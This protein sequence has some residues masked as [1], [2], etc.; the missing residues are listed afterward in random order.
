MNEWGYIELETK[1]AIQYDTISSEGKAIFA[2]EIV[3]ID[4]YVI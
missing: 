3:E 1:L 2:A 4:Q